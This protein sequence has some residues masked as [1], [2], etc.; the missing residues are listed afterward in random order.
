MPWHQHIWGFCP[1]S[2]SNTSLSGWTGNFILFL[3][4]RAM[5]VFEHKNDYQ[6]KIPKKMQ[7]SVLQASCCKFHKFS[8]SF[9]P[10]FKQWSYWYVSTWSQRNSWRECVR[11]LASLFSWRSFLY[12]QKSVGVWGLPTQWGPGVFPALVADEAC[13]TAW[14]RKR[15]KTL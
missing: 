5:V 10:T 13:N 15:G 11:V 3:N 4:I 1:E 7:F 8:E 14:A 2:T 9:S 6:K 12:S